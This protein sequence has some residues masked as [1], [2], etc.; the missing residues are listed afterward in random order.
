MRPDPTITLAAAGRAIDARAASIPPPR[1][2]IA[3]Q[4]IERAAQHIAGQLGCSSI[5][6][7]PA[8]ASAS[9][10]LRW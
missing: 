9:A 10:F 4:R 2:A 8:A 5:S 6:A 1:V 3:G 7:A